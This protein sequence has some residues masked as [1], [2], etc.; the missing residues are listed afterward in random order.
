MELATSQ[1][2]IFLREWIQSS[3]GL[4]DTSRERNLSNTIEMLM[5]ETAAL[6]ERVKVGAD[7]SNRGS[8]EREVEFK[9]FEKDLQSFRKDAESSSKKLKAFVKVC[10]KKIDDVKTRLLH[11]AKMAATDL[12]ND[13]SHK[14]ARV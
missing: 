13:S 11:D 2:N 4:L 8:L 5:K 3:I 7:E 9:R 12:S 1:V 10:Q 14:R 6:C